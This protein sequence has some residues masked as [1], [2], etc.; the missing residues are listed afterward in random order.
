MSD[1]DS[2][3]SIGGICLSTQEDSDTSEVPLVATK[4]IE[5]RKRIGLSSNSLE[6]ISSA[7]SASEGRALKKAKAKYE[8]FIEDCAQLSGDVTE[9]VWETAD[10]IEIRRAMK[11]LE[12]WRDRL[13]KVIKQGR[14]LD[15]I[16]IDTPLSNEQIGHYKSLLQQ[17]KCDVAKTLEQVKAQDKERMIFADLP[18]KPEVLKLPIFHGNGSEDFVKFEENVKEAFKRNRI[19][20]DNQ[21]VKLRQ[22]CL[23]G[24]AKI[25]IPESTKDID[26]AWTILKSCYSDPATVMSH[27]KDQ[28]TSF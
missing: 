10:D 7:T 8:E 28:L 11:T 25:L 13:N 26:E 5:V 2:V 22:D 17:T 15:A 27:R 9:H 14:D 12:N 20:K 1:S 21:L 4:A 19:V 6:S 18:G 16:C 3:S 23:R 24:Q